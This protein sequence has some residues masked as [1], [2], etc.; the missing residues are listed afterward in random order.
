MT[1][2]QDIAPAVG[3]LQEAV[4]SGPVRLR[5]FRRA[6]AVYALLFAAGLAAILLDLPPGLKAAGLGL[7][8]PGAGFLAAG[9]WGLLWFGLTLVLFLA[10]VFLRFATGAVAFPLAVWT[11]SAAL[12]GFVAGEQIA[13]WAP[14]LAAAL[15]AATALGGNILARRKSIAQ[16]LEREQRNRYLPAAVAETARRA[17]ARP[18]VAARELSPR[19]LAISRFVL[20]RA[21]QPIDKFDGFTHIDQFQPAALRYQLNFL[22]YAL[23]VMQCQYAPSFHGYLSLAQRQLLE[24]FLDRRVWGYWIYES[25]LGRFSLDFDP[26]GWYNIMLG[27]FFNLNLGLYASNTGDKRYAEPGALRFDLNR[28]KSYA[29][30]ARSINKVAV[31]NY[32]ASALCLYSC[33][34]GFVYPY[35]NLLG[36][37]GIHVHDRVYGAANAAQ[38]M[39]RFRQR[40]DEDFTGRNGTIKPGVDKYTG[41]SVEIVAGLYTELG[42]TWLTSPFFPDISQRSWAVARTEG[43]KL[44]A[45][46]ELELRTRSAADRVDLGNYRKSELT[47]L[48]L[49]AIAAREVGDEA[50]GAA[51]LRRMD[52]VG[53]PITEGGVLRYNASTYTNAHIA[54]AHF[55]RR[56]DWRATLMQGPPAAVLH[57][58]ILAGARYPDVLVARAF[59]DGEDLSLVLYPGGA[60]GRQTIKVERL[61]PGRRYNVRGASVSEFSANPEGTMDLELILDGRVQVSI[62]PTD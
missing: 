37:G 50:I 11:G 39:P 33:E 21:L 12:A 54:I 1:T 49:L 19:E 43:F 55:L 15:V 23:A 17:V 5:L 44:D 40:L 35:C 48:A 34:P 14:G 4:G 60:P 57:G 36:L 9:A 56:G 28:H 62:S 2:L 45:N 38:I 13:A 46:G 41:L 16:L 3:D 52:R 31:R 20:D 25:I 51:A 58:P 26:V 7:W 8:L 47:T 59:S 10:A 42:Y 61:R 22:H 24:K 53:E 32:N 29:H 27:G 18:E 6:L 30:D